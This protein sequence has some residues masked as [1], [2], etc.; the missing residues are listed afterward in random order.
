M[1]QI[2]N[3]IKEKLASHVKSAHNIDMS[4]LVMG[5]SL[6]IHHLFNQAT[7]ASY[8]MTELGAQF[9][10]DR[11]TIN[12][13]SGRRGILTFAE[14]FYLFYII[15]YFEKP[16][17]RLPKIV[18]ILNDIFKVLQEASGIILFPEGFRADFFKQWSQDIAKDTVKT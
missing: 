15:L 5:Y 14:F 9:G 12:H 10:I 2:K 13:L 6:L 18:S 3:K 1:I 11:T 4:T 7:G 8:K 17:N 16:E